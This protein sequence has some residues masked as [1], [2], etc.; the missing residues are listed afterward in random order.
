MI[1]DEVDYD[2]RYVAFLDLLGFS[3]LVRRADVPEVR[4]LIQDLVGHLQH[5]P[6]SLRLIKFTQ[7]SDCVIL[8]SEKSHDG[9]KAVLSASR[10]IAESVMLEGC[11]VRGGIAS[12]KL[13]HT[14]KLIFG[15]GFLSAYRHD[16]RGAPPR[17]V[18]ASD[19]VTDIGNESGFMRMHVRSDPADA[20]T[21]LHS[22]L[23]VEYYDVSDD[24]VPFPAVIWNMPEIIGRMCESLDVPEDVRVK[25]AWFR[26]YWNETVGA[27]QGRLS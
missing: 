7:F 11:L 27:R 2:D 4:A 19:V 25:W 24:P 14:D 18:I 16:A 21:Y 13:T 6:A 12:G 9:L 17:V 8:S 20:T 10:L 5:V 23:A 3:S 26:R 15:P 1:A 22:L